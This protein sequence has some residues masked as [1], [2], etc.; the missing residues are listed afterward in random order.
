M[1]FEK[2][3]EFMDSFLEMGIPG[4]DCIIYKDGECVLRHFNGYADKEAGVR[5]N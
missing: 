3:I 2:T 4:Y 5:I 1:N